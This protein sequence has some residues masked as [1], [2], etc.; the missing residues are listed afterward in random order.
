M[1]FADSQEPCYEAN[2]DEVAF[3]VLLVGLE[4]AT[5]IKREIVGYFN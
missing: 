1:H 2:R 5:K 4:L 3:A